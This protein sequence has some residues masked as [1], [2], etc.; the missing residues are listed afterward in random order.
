[1]KNVSTTFYSS[2]WFNY[3][4]FKAKRA[5][6]VIS[7]I[8]LT[9]FLISAG[10]GVWWDF[11]NIQEKGF[12]QKID[13]ECLDVDE[14]IHVIK[15]LAE[16]GEVSEMEA[17]ARIASLEKSKEAEGGP[18]DCY[19]AGIVLIGIGSV[20][21][22]LTFVILFVRVRRRKS[23]YKPRAPKRRKKD[24]DSINNF[25]DFDDFDGSDNPIFS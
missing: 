5:A 23:G 3:S 22:F 19:R 6:K 17:E 9:A 16:H 13:S 25:D 20:F 4:G 21:L 8:L 18:G 10:L 15:H 14:Q 11:G 12:L 24:D 2:E 7:S 1:M